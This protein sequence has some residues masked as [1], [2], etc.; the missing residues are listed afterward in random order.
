MFRVGPASLLVA[1]TGSSSQPKRRPLFHPGGRCGSCRST[2]APST[3]IWFLETIGKPVWG[4]QSGQ[5]AWD[6]WSRATQPALTPQAVL[7][8]KTGPDELRRAPSRA[9]IS[10]VSGPLGTDEIVACVMAAAVDTGDIERVVV[11]NDQSVW[12]RL[13]P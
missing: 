10:T 6:R 4:V 3:R 7:A 11:V 1:S 13:V 8:R 5:Q 2:Q 12:A 9:G